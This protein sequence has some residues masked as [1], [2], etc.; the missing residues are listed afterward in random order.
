MKQ[1]ITAFLLMTI[2]TFVGCASRTVKMSPEE[3]QVYLNK[4]PDVAQSLLSGKSMVRQ[5]D[6]CE[7]TFTGPCWKVECISSAKNLSEAQCWKTPYEAFGIS[8]T[9]NAP[10]QTTEQLLATCKAAHEDAAKR[11]MSCFD[12]FSRLQGNTVEK[13][14]VTNTQKLLKQFCD[15]KD[16]TCTRQ[17]TKFGKGDLNTDGMRSSAYKRGV[18]QVSSKEKSG[19]SET[20]EYII[21]K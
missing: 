4:T 2:L 7:S 1:T 11:R 5:S 18:Y 19:N 12:Y 20:Y 10:N 15:M 16:V 17:Y 13:A 3:T 21:L 14:D 9:S 6:Y 8:A